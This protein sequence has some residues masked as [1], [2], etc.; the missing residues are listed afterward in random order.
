MRYR[1]AELA[2]T[3]F[4]IPIR[5]RTERDLTDSERCPPQIE[6]HVGCEAPRRASPTRDDYLFAASR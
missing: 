5:R 1:R 2:T 4:V 6:S 3:V